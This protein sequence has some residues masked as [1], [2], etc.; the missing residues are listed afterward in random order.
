MF[1]N[2]LSVLLDIFNPVSLPNGQLQQLGQW[3]LTSETYARRH[4]LV[5]V[6]EAPGFQ[7]MAMLNLSSVLSDVQGI[8]RYINSHKVCVG[9]AGVEVAW[10]NKQD[11]NQE[12][13]V[14][15]PV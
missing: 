5:A 13:S 1:A 11:L 8:W 7:L 6:C 2:D 4:P 9:R 3:P 14:H 15:V 12:A 10:S